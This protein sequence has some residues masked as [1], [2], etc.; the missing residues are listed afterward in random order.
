MIPHRVSEPDVDAFI[1]AQPVARLAT[2][3]A[4]GIP[5]VVPI[6]YVYDGRCLYT[7]LDL[8]TK[9]VP[10]LR[11]KRVRNIAENPKIAVVVDHYSEDWGQLGYVLIRGS[12]SVL[13]EGN[14]RARAEVMLREKYPQ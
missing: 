4:N 6:C 2:A 3:D 14:E 10:V 8:K 12:A 9:S 11:L 7:P 13:E 1:R 5:H